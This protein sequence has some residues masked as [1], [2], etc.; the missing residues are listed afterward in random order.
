MRSWLANYRLPVT[1]KLSKNRAAHRCRFSAARAF[2]KQLFSSYF[3]QQAFSRLTIPGDE[4]GLLI[5]RIILSIAGAKT[6][7]LR[8]LWKG[9]T[10]MAAAFPPAA[11]RCPPG[12]AG[13]CGH[14]PC[15]WATCSPLPALILNIRIYT[16]LSE[17]GAAGVRIQKYH[18]LRSGAGGW[19]LRRAH[20]ACLQLLPPV[21]VGIFQL[22]ALYL[23]DEREREGKCC[24]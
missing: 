21:P 2:P 18:R 20:C 9:E 6:Q 15:T 17:K 10:G 5:I 12:P 19:A 4:T 13:D 1:A 16:L 14:S 22:R 23:I 24:N 11:T 3:L 7:P 8:S